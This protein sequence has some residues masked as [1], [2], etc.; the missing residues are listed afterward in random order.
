MRHIKEIVRQLW[1]IPQMQWSL[2]QQLKHEANKGIC[3]FR[4]D[5]LIDH[6]LHDSE[7]GITNIKYGDCEIIVS[8]TT[9][10]RRLH[11]AA[12]AIESIMQQ[13]LKANRIILWLSHED[14]KSIPFNLKLLEK[15]GLEIMECDDLLSYKKI[16][17]T[18]IRYPNDVII[19]IDDDVYY[20]FDILEH[21]ITAYQ[22][23]PDFIHC[24]RAHRMTFY[25]TGEL[26]PYMEWD[27]YVE[28]NGPDKLNFFTGCGGVLYPPH[29]L[30]DEVL[31]KSVF[32][33]ICRFADDVWLNAMALKKGTLVNK[34]FT[35]NLNGEDFLDNGNVQDTALN[36]INTMGEKLND[37]QIEAVFTK[38]NLY[39]RLSQ[40]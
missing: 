22:N 12:F 30:D 19:T 29:C 16:I 15:R 24:N 9:Y 21:L 25:Q 33:D 6:I 26:K 20:D 4:R 17:P 31:D 28:N 37:I 2:S 13:T 34:V 35:R 5:Y 10:G 40:K 38:Y 23:N 36:K 32:M 8:L 11:E 14:Y 1:G 3:Q 7:P 39:G 27:W 18:I